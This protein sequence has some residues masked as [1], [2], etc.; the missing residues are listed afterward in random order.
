MWATISRQRRSVRL[1]VGDVAEEVD[2]C[3][4]FVVE[5]E[6]DFLSVSEDIL[7]MVNIELLV[8]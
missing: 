3:A 1:V 6:D 7:W 8:C 5:Q 2:A 4:C